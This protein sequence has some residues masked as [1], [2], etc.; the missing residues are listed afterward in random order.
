MNETT[1]SDFLTELNDQL[2]N[3]K[4]TVPE[5]RLGRCSILFR[6]AINLAQFSQRSDPIGNNLIY[7]NVVRC[8]TQLVVKLAYSSKCRRWSVL[9]HSL[10]GL[11][12]FEIIGEEEKQNKRA[13][14]LP[15]FAVYIKY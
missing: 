1:P 2:L 10:R 12:G 5:T 9:I 8:Q 13:T 4:K 15:I 11:N 6:S 7:A 3:D 14:P